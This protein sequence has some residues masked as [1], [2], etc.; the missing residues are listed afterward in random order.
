MKRLL[1]ILFSLF[2]IGASAQTNY[3]AKT[4]RFSSIG[5]DSSY[6]AAK[7]F[8]NYT[9]GKLRIHWGDSTSTVW[10]VA[11]NTAMTTDTLGIDG[12]LTATYIPYATGSYTLGDS[13]LYRYTG[14]LIGLG[15]TVPNN[16]F[17]IERD[18]ATTNSIYYPFRL[19]KTSSGT[20]TAG[21]GVG[22]QFE[23]ET[24]PGNNEITGSIQSAVTLV[25]GAAEESDFIISMMGGGTLNE[26]L[27]LLGSGAGFNV[28]LGAGFAGSAR[29]IRAKG[30]A[31]NIAVTVSG[32]G[33]GGVTLS[34]PSAGNSIIVG[35]GVNTLD[36]T[37]NN[38]TGTTNTITGTSSGN[39]SSVLTSSATNTINYAHDFKHTTNGTPTAGIGTGIRFYTRTASPSNDEI[40]A[41]IESVTTDVI[42][43]SEDFDLVLSTMAGGSGAAE[44]VR[45]TSTGAIAVNGASSYGSSGQVL[46][47]TGNA[48]PTWQT[49]SSGG[50]TIEE[51]GTPLTQR[52]GLNFIGSGITATDDAGGDETDVTLDGDLNTWSA[53]TRA[54]GFDTFTATPSSANFAATITDEIGAGP[55]PLAHP[56]PN[57]QTASYT[58]VLTDDGKIVEMNVASANNL[59]IPLNA[60][61]AFATNTLITIVQYGA[62]LTTVVATGG[63]T[64]RS[65]AGVLTSPGQYTPMVLEKIA[66]DEWYLWNGSVGSSNIAGTATND[67]ATAGNIGE[68]SSSLIAAGSAVSLTT[69]TSANVTS[70]SLTAGDWD[71]EGAIN[72]TET[73]S[74]VTARTGGI[75]TTS[76][77]LPTDGSE[78]ENGFLTTVVT[79]KA[80]ITVPRKRISI[81]ATTTVYLVARA[82]FSA[83]TEAAYGQLTARRVR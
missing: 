39:N 38:I 77:T 41:M 15:T 78:V 66:T 33:T 27:R 26:G 9:S 80:G 17:H 24:T 45:F 58:L 72:Y 5:I 61:V 44:R 56:T 74:T 16:M 71:V 69:N 53:I 82:V 49:P 34:S 36:A 13:P 57:R 62:G 30:T 32:K 81:S 12:P 42:G 51:E 55:V 64:I 76:A 21:I 67:N 59:T 14:G 43:S 47:S 37:T 7:L 10:P 79:T 40:G 31:T 50:H 29:G 28:D 54:S 20:P 70:L 68:H 75:S 48:A 35:N 22:M 1:G 60:T 73:T 11:P 19:T 18:D 63:V 52:T 46:T 8:M 6:S 4:L 2:L 23:T 65:S 3:Y 83:G 25:T